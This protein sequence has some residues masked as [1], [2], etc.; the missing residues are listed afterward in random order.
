MS[1]SE[2][3]RLE[4][5]I[6]LREINELRKPGWMIERSTKLESFESH[7]SDDQEME[8]ISDELWQR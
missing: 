4:E 1:L 8:T 6:N 5:M 3:S 7:E 2:M